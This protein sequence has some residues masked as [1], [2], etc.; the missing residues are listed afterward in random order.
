[1]LILLLIHSK[2]DGP[3]SLIPFFESINAEVQPVKLYEGDRL[4]DD[5]GKF[6]AIVV[7]GG[8]M[9][10]Y[11]EE[12]YPFLKNETVFLRRAVESNLPI[13]GICLGAQMI[14]KSLGAR[15]T[16]S[17]VREIGWKGVSINAIGKK[18]SIF[19]GVAERIKVFQWHG[20]TFEI[21]EGAHLLASSEEVPNQAFR[22]RNAYGLQFHIEITGDIIEDWTKKNPAQQ[23]ELL[24]DL[25]RFEPDHTRQTQQIFRNFAAFVNQKRGK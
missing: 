18:E 21:P 17:P 4:P 15:V 9:N 5:P 22:Y 20:D 8:H 13:L 25:E 19:Q 16:K 14:A 7:L 12:K 2:R 1:M 23:A 3:G 10:V 6:D 24:R 11:E